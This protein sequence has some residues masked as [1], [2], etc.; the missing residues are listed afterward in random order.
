V[1][2]QT[3][4]LWRHRAEA[5]ESLV[6]VGGEPYVGEMLWDLGELLGGWF[7]GPWT[8]D[9][10]L[11]GSDGAELRGDFRDMRGDGCGYGSDDDAE[12]VGEAGDADDGRT[13]ATA[14]SSLR[15]P[16]SDDEEDAFFGWLGERFGPY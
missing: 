10:L 4:V 6:D 1:S 14:D 13:G 5:L 11:S 16:I 15:E 9:G 2:E 3:L 7:E 12:A 8:P